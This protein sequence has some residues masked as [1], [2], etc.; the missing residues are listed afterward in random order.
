MSID[1]GNQQLLRNSLRESKWILILWLL[2]F[3]WVV[4]YCGWFGYH[5]PDQPLKL[6]FGIPSWV[7]WGV[8]LPWAISAAI[9]VVFAL[10]AMQDDSL[11]TPGKNLD[12][13][14]G[15]RLNE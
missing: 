9:S 10:T 8:F 3:A 15:D 2:A 13:M 6:V 7:F 11:E 4:G 5:D 14:S 12:D 1:R